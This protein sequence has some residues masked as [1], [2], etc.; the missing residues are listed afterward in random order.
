MVMVTIEVATTRVLVVLDS[1]VAL[2]LLVVRRPLELDAKTAIAIRMPATLVSA[3]VQ[4]AL[5]RARAASV[6]T[7]GELL[8]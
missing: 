7:R 8:I 2:V 5:T 3:A 1:A 6:R 4:E